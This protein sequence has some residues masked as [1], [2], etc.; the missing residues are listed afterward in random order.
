MRE[1]ERTKVKSSVALLKL[2]SALQSC[3]CFLDKSVGCLGAPPRSD[4]SLVGCGL[5]ALIGALTVHRAEFL[6]TS[7]FGNRIKG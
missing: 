3:R 6:V 7:I 2:Q 5:E 4:T 1:H